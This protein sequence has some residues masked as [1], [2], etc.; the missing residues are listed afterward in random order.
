MIT[1]L[2]IIHKICIEK[3]K[4]KFNEIQSV[5]LDDI[6]D[7][8]YFTFMWYYSNVNKLIENKI[9]IVAAG[10]GMLKNFNYLA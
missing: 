3:S 6:F 10:N 2:N 5:C 7:M 9:Q 8:N 1:D 4:L